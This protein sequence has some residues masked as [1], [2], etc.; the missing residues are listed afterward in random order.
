MTSHSKGEGVEAGV[1][2]CDVGSEGGVNCCDVTQ[3][4]LATAVL[5]AMPGS[6]VTYCWCWE[7]DDMTIRCNWLH[8]LHDCSCWHASEFDKQRSKVVG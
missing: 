2:M 3:G 5:C 7:W 6:R 1:T 4:T 8:R